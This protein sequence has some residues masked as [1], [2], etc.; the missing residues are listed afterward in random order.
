MQQYKRNN[1]RWQGYAHIKPICF[2]Q[3]GSVILKLGMEEP[4]VKV[5]EDKLNPFTPEMMIGEDKMYEYIW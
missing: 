5:F 1:P 3:N 4:M 2:Q